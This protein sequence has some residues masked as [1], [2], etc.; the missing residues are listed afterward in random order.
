M[1]SAPKESAT[2]ST[3][4]DERLARDAG[5]AQQDRASKDR[6]T[7][8][9]REVTDSIRL[10]A[11]RQSFFQSALPDL[12][13]IPGYHV[14]WLTTTNPRDPVHARFRLGYEPIKASD[15]PG[16][17]YAALKDGEHA[18]FIG[19]NEMIACKLPIHLYNLYMTEAHHE[20]PRREEEKLSATLEVIAQEARRK[21]SSV[22][23]GDGSAALGKSI[24]PPRFDGA[25]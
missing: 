7:T 9:S 22:D 1:A 19:V 17:E 18:G 6:E 16:W 24:A 21:G 3:Q 14:C 20:Q 8:E 2:L 15:I 12:P 10:E 11:F 13:S 25:G 4:R 23:M 5:Q